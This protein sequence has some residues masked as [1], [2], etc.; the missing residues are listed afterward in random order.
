M[1]TTFKKHIADIYAGLLSTKD[2]LLQYQTPAVFA[3]FSESEKELILSL[4]KVCDEKL[5]Y[6]RSVPDVE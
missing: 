5:T 4:S 6:T 3:H 1:T 2:I